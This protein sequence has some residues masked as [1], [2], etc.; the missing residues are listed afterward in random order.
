[1]SSP[2]GRFTVIG[3]SSPNDHIEAL[4]HKFVNH[5][6]HT[7]R[8]ISTISVH[9]YINVRIDVG[10]HSSDNIAFSASRFATDNCSR[11][12]RYLGGRV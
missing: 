6:L 8:V 3:L 5:Q 11:D 2:E 10:E 12:S 4:F 7:C 9:E 1:M